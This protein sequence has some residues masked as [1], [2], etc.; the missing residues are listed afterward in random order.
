MSTAFTTWVKADPHCLSHTSRSSRLGRGRPTRRQRRARRLGLEHLESRLLLTVPWVHIDRPGGFL[1]TSFGGDGVVTTDVA[2]AADEVLEVANLGSNET[3]KLVALGTSGLARYQPDGTLDSTFD[4]DGLVTFPPGVILRTLAVQADGKLLVGGGTLG[5]SS[6]FVLARYSDAG[7][8]DP[9]FGAGGV[10][11]TT[12]GVN[13]WI[14]SLAVQPDGKIVAA[15]MSSNGANNDFA[16]AR[17]NTNGSLDDGNP[18][19]DSMPADRFGTDGSVTTP[20]GSGDDDAYSVAL[21]SDGKIVVAGDTF[22]GSDFDL[23]LVRYNADGSLDDGT[24]ADSTPLDQFGAAGVVVANLGADDFAL[25]VA[26]QSD[27]RLVVAG[28]TGGGSSYQMAVARCLS[29]G[30]PDSSFGSGGVW[31]ASQT[32]WTGGLALQF[33]GKL[34][35][36]GRTLNQQM[37]VARLLPGGSLDSSFDGDGLLTTAVGTSSGANAVLIRPDGK[38]V[39]AGSG[40]APAMDFA[41][42][43]YGDGPVGTSEG[44]AFAPLVLINDPGDTQ[45]TA[46]VDYGDASPAVVSQLT[47]P[48]LVLNHTYQHGGTYHVRVGVRDKDG[49]EGTDVLDVT[50]Q[51]PSSVHGL[52]YE[53]MNGDGMYWDGVDALVAGVEFQLWR[54][55]NGDGTYDV[56]QATTTSDVN[57]EFAFPNVP[58]GAYE[59]RQQ[60]PP[61]DPALATTATFADVFVP[62]N[63]A[64]VAW[65]G[66]SGEPSSCEIVLGSGLMF[67]TTYRGSI[68]GLAFSDVNSNRVYDPGTDAFGPGMT[69]RL[70]GDVNQDGTLEELTTQ[71]DTHGNFEFADLIPGDYRLDEILG[72]GDLPTTDQVLWVKVLSRQA[73]VAL[74]GQSTPLAGTAR[75]DQLVK[76]FVGG[77]RAHQ[78]LA[79]GP[80]GDLY[81]ASATTSQIVRYHGATGEYR[82]IFIDQDVGLVGVA[83]P[84]L[85]LAFQGNYLY[86]ANT[87]VGQVRRYDSATGLQDRSFA[88]QLTDLTEAASLS[89]GD[90]VFDAAGNLYVSYRTPVGS[91]VFKFA[92]DGASAP[93][94]THVIGFETSV[95]AHVN[96]AQGLTIGPDGKL[97]VASEADHRV[98]RFAPDGTYLGDFVAA[99][100]GGLA[101]P[102]DL[103]FGP[104]FNGDGVPDL[105]VASSATNEVLGYAGTTGAFLGRKL[106]A[107]RQLANPVALAFGPRGEMFVVGQNSDNVLRVIDGVRF[108][109]LAGP[110][111]R[112]GSTRQFGRISGRE[113][114]DRNANGVQDAGEPGVKDCVI[115]VVDADPARFRPVTATLTDAQGDY[116]FENLIPGD[117]V[118][119]QV[120]RADW[121]QTLPGT[122]PPALLSDMG[123]GAHWIDGY[124]FGWEESLTVYGLA[125]IA[126]PG[127]ITSQTFY[128]GTMTLRLGPGVASDPAQPT[129]LDSIPA[130]IV[131]F[132]LW[133]TAAGSGMNIVSGDGD[134]NLASDGPLYSPGRFQED[135]ANPALAG[136]D[137]S[138]PFAVHPFGYPTLYSAAPLH[139]AASLDRLP[140]WGVPFQSTEPVELLDE[141]G[142]PLAQL[143]G[144]RFVMIDPSLPPPTAYRISLAGGDE[145]THVDFGNVDQPLSA[146]QGTWKIV[147]NPQPIPGGAPAGLQYWGNTIGVDGDAQLDRLTREW[148]WYRIGDAGPERPLD[149][150]TLISARSQSNSVSLVYGDPAQGDPIRVSLTYQL[151]AGSDLEAQLLKAVS[152]TNLTSGPLDVH[153]FQYTDLDVDS[154]FG[155]DQDTVA[156]PVTVGGVTTMEQT[157]G[158]GSVVH[159]QVP[160]DPAPAAVTIAPYDS[161]LAELQNGTATQL[162]TGNAFAAGQPGNVTFAMQ[163]DFA[164]VPSGGTRDI[165]GGAQVDTGEV[166]LPNPGGTGRNGGGGD[167]GNGGGVGI[168]VGG[169]GGGSGFPFSGPSAPGPGDGGGGGEIVEPRWYEPAIALGFDYLATVNRF[170]TLELPVGF[171]DNHYRLY[172]YNEVTQQYEL[173]G[174]PLVNGRLLG[175]QE[176][177]LRQF[178]PQGLSRFRILGIEAGPPDSQLPVDPV[179]ALGFPTKLGF[180]NEDQVFEFTMIGIPEVVYFDAPQAFVEEKNFGKTPGVVEVGDLVTWHSGLADEVQGLAYGA[181]AFASL[182]AAQAAIVAHQ[183]TGITRIA[184][185]TLT[186]DVV[187]VA[188]DPRNTPAGTVTINFSEIVTG[189]DVADFH[190]TRDGTTVSLSELTVGGAGDSYTLDLSTKTAAEG[191]YVLVLTAAG[192]GIQ[193]TAGTPLTGDAADTF[194][195][196]PWHNYANQFDVT[197]LQGAPDGLVT[198]IDVLTLIA[199]INNHLGQAAVPGA[200]AVGPPY[201][202]VTGA[203]GYPDGLVTALDVLSVI[204]YVNLHPLGSAEG[205]STGAS[206]RVLAAGQVQVA[207]LGAR[208]TT[209]DSPFDSSVTLRSPQVLGASG[210]DAE[211]DAFLS[212]ASGVA[213]GIPGVIGRPYFPR[214][215]R[216]TRADSRLRLPMLRSAAALRFPAE[217]GHTSTELDD[218]GTWWGPAELESA[219]AQM[220]DE[221][222]AAWPRT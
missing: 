173:A 75:V 77:A 131:N 209:E 87:D 160:Q 218:H 216:P 181:T 208:A 73:S 14:Y 139:V 11:T 132:S 150:L 101:Q 176:L 49:A 211:L 164:A 6:Q 126:W 203:Q 52:K 61:G 200:P 102:T 122:S 187:D 185:Q 155:V 142:D 81:T 134:G 40:T 204:N 93:T 118:V 4:S 147:A 3:A 180:M 67:G 137:F 163:W 177:D 41:L 1:D 29:N 31:V 156:Y 83:G 19:T 26:V 174:A 197:G 153:F 109:A 23:A 158:A 220:V 186:A 161:L 140:A 165:Q 114:D 82:D 148:F 129:H 78:G 193:G 222:A 106:A 86:V 97:Y 127:G 53:D 18:L 151:T 76:P 72:A 162:T 144:M 212:G 202:D 74:T 35:I 21:Q 69:F 12:I 175:G 168:G 92:T 65:P 88:L 201:Y 71:S 51:T 89:V 138:L 43:R 9:T 39:V 196:H 16:V 68:H 38:I 50:V 59:V 183:Y 116:S 44:G 105:Y 13:D 219:L 58:P 22:Q 125:T 115:V 119:M 159:T 91:G 8:L 30:T 112:F 194:A 33:D 214:S 56:Q 111:L 199:Y 141:W 195:V 55:T 79:V 5:L 143:V 37:L 192:S 47:S 171:G 46:T 2:G 100:A 99:A 110:D 107:T 145:R 27:G 108:E 190:L 66:Q 96:A 62:A 45:W 167:G 57:G 205:E 128:N 210:A 98:C 80:D 113:F 84:G 182:S 157:G 34:V 172:L 124:P 24:V 136:A 152:I 123:P 17:Y 85:G 25:R 121:A 221:I 215:D 60:L 169:G 213:Q 149:S 70:S 48:Q 63:T 189:V 146:E 135:D 184:T 120:W 90:L 103:A 32:S 166:V 15:G 54:D 191:T 28:H 117:Y 20:L 178:A 94:F 95:A 42:V 130:E 64:L 133:G 217:L 188:P 104:D 198:T 170:A 179:N 154:A 7:V 10:V 36:A 206:H 207:S